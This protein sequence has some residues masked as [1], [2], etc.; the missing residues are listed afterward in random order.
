MEDIATA[1]REQSTTGHD[2]AQQVEMVAGSSETV[3]A[4]INRIDTLTHGLN[5]IVANI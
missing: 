1:A 5:R 3:S 4:Q 2:I